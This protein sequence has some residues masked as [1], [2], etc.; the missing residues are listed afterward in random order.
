[1]SVFIWVAHKFCW[2]FFGFCCH[3]GVGAGES[4][5]K[6]IAFPWIERIKYQI[7]DLR[8]WSDGATLK[9]TK[10]PS[11]SVNIGGV[12]DNFVS[13]TFAN[14]RV[15]SHPNQ[16][17]ESRMHFNGLATRNAYISNEQAQLMFVYYGGQY[18]P[19][20]E[21]NNNNHFDALYRKPIK[22]I[23]PEPPKLLK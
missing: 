4:C 10:Y 11:W 23:A 12:C 13:I 8:F 20:L 22:V 5:H 6:F 15:S 18:N 9:T 1:M 7:Y 2:G 14:Y 16:T 21:P 19:N 17:T 3:L